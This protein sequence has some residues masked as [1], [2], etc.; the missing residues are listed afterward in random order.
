M[1]SFALQSYYKFSKFARI[2]YKFLN[3]TLFL[4]ASKAR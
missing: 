3:I 1:I 4:F 2:F